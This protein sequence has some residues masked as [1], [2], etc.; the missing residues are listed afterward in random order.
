MD[1]SY[2][3]D[4]DIHK[5]HPHAFHVVSGYYLHTTLGDLLFVITFQQVLEIPALSSPW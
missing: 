2:E 5:E 1:V 3:L 4:V